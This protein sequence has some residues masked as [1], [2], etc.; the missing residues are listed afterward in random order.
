[1]VE[2]MKLL[3]HVLSATTALGAALCV[4]YLSARDG[5]GLFTLLPAGMTEFFVGS[6][7]IKWGAFGLV[8]VSLLVKL[9]VIRVLQRRASENRA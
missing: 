1:M 6:E 4:A 3:S 8:V 2:G 5:H 7:A 9:P